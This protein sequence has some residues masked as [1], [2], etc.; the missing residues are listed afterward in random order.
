MV[1]SPLISTSLAEIFIFP[2]Q[3]D[4]GPLGLSLV[5]SEPMDSVSG[6]GEIDTFLSLLMMMKPT[7]ESLDSCPI[8]APFYKTEMRI[9]F[10]DRGDGSQ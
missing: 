10:L 1:V 2:L 6:D 3:N 5:T 9:L 8:P 7:A 4:T